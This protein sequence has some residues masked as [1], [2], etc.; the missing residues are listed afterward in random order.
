MRD[1]ALC[2]NPEGVYCDYCADFLGIVTG[3]H[4][5]AVAAPR[6]RK[7][8]I[9]SGEDVSINPVNSDDRKRTEQTDDLPGYFCR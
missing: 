6:P 9:S 3:G 4:S 5:P 2:S 8:D 1:C 7:I